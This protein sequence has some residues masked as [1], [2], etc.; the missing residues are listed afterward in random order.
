[1]DNFKVFTWDEEYYD[2]KGVLCDKMEQ[3]GFKPV[4]IIDPGT[5][6]EDGY[7]MYEE[8]VEKGYF[9]KDT[10]G[11]IYVNEVWP[12]ESVFPVRYV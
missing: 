11:N 4:T 9:A 7:F 10:E 2:K 3:L 5:K 12:G 6:K 1:M 8:G